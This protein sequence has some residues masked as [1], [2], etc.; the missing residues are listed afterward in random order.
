MSTT[1]RTSWLGSMRNLTD[2]PTVLDG[3]RMLEQRLELDDSYGLRKFH[4]CRPDGGTPT[5][6]QILSHE[7]LQASAAAVTSGT[8]TSLTDTGIGWT[9]NDFSGKYGPCW[10]QIV[11]DAGGAGAAPESEVR[12]ISANTTDTLTVG[13]A[14]SAAP[15]VGDTYVII[16]LG[17]ATDGSAGDCAAETLGAAM[18]TFADNDFGWLQYYGFYPALVTSTAAQTGGV[19]IAHGGS[20]ACVDNTLTDDGES[21]GVWLGG[22]HASDAA[23]LTWSAFLT[24][25]H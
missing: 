2:T 16:R 17:T 3:V 6:G 18:A 20:A 25:P 24:L 23:T 8:T 22:D 5:A 11:D 7:L 14:F 10:A 12:L 15:A 13:T 1:Y 4:V 9:A 21:L 19:S